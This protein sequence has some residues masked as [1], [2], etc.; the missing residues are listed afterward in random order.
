MSQSPD[1]VRVTHLNEVNLTGNPTVVPPTCVRQA[2]NGANLFK[3]PPDHSNY[4]PIERVWSILEQHWN[5]TLLDLLTAVL[6]LA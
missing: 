4:H 6:N 3:F 2:D 1:S 5:G